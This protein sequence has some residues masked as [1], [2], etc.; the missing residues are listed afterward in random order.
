MAFLHEF[1]QKLVEFIFIAIVAF[2]GVKL[3]ISFRKKKN[4]EEES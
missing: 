1:Y 2:G 4:A 3:G